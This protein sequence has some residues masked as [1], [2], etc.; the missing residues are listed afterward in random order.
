VEIVWE[1]NGLV[2]PSVG[3]WEPVGPPKWVVKV[4]EKIKGWVK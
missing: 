4:V 3:L 2:Q 1:R